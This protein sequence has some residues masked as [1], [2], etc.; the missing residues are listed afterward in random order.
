MSLAATY[1]F[2]SSNYQID[3]S[4]LTQY[5]VSILPKILNLGRKNEKDS[6]TAKEFLSKFSHINKCMT[7]NF[8][9]LFGEYLDFD[10]RK[11]VSISVFAHYGKAIAPP[12]Y[13]QLILSI[14]NNFYGLLGPAIRCNAMYEDA[15]LKVRVNGR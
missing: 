7:S 8:S 1:I 13:N 4:E 2:T 15:T 12:F 14:L 9:D 10:K 5:T 3:F 11:E 6:I